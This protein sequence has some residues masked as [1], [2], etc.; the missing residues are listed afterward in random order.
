MSAQTA[1]TKDH[2]LGSLNNQDLFLP[3]LFI[4]G[5]WEFKIKVQQSQFLPGLQKAILSLGPHRVFF[6]FFNPIGPKA[7]PLGP[8]LTLMI[9]L[10]APSLIQPHC[11]K[12][13]Q[14]RN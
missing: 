8:Y 4:S 11:G 13:L 5:N 6:F 7:P 9:S 1:I 3:A 12:K 14:H 10:Q 2:T